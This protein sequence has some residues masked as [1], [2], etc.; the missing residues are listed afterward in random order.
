[1]KS[2]N[3]STNRNP[4]TRMNRSGS[5]LKLAHGMLLLAMAMRF[6]SAGTAGLSFFILAGYALQGRAQAVQALALSWLFSMLSEGVAPLASAASVGRYV[7]VIS[8]AIS[9]LF[10]V[11]QAK[12][13][14]SESQL[15]LAT[16]AFGGFVIIHSMLFSPMP[17]VSIL[18]AVLW[19]VVMMT[20][21]L[22]WAGMNVQVRAQLERQL[23]GGLVL[24][25]LIS[26]PLIFTG[27]GYL[28]NESGFQGALGHP[29]AFGP[30]MAMLGAWVA[31]RL[32]AEP[33]PLW[34]NIA[35]AGLCLVMVVMS[36]ARTAGFALV[37]GL[38]ITTIVTLL[39]SG[40]SV[41]K[42][43][44]GLR[45]GRLRMLPVL[46]VVGVVLSG[47]MLGNILDNYISK[48]GRSEATGIV[49]AYDKS[50]G[51]LIDAMLDN[52]KADPWGGVGFGIASKSQDMFVKRDPV[53]DLPTSAA[54]EKGVL[55]F[56]VLEEL[57]IVGFCLF[58][59]LIGLFLKRAA[60]GGVVP[61]AVLITVLLFNFGESTLFSTSGFGLFPL[62][63]LAWA[64]TSRSRLLKVTQ[65]G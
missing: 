30:T 33:R 39:A 42:I 64:V 16:L 52:I 49:D 58:A 23:L 25:A 26:L 61:L 31:S 4:L 34:R 15:I 18:K 36:G 60:R 13:G 48:S 27:V 53:F 40:L 41:N 28:R 63:L 2:L 55:P 59:A 47:P 6:A 56:A 50:R 21:L 7:V 51:G 14:R 45:S 35:M 32:L 9:V 37:I 1:M 62:I 20:L 44:P 65:L 22:A 11:R 54:I 19:T 38:S 10:R 29:Q 3:L 17:D 5:S 24:L 12:I 57:G 8:A 46:V 43:M